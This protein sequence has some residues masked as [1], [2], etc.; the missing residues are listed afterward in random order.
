MWFAILTPGAHPS[1]RRPSSDA[2]V[3]SWTDGDRRRIDGPAWAV[4]GGLRVTRRLLREAGLPPAPPRCFV[5]RARVGVP[6]VAAERARPGVLRL[7]EGVAPPP[8]DPA[9]RA[10][11]LL[12]FVHLH[13]LA[14][15]EDP[16]L[17]EEALLVLLEQDFTLVAPL[18]I[19]PACL[20]ALR[21]LV[22]GEPRAG[23]G[24]C[25]T[26]LPGSADQ[27]ARVEARAA[28]RERERGA[29]RGHGRRAA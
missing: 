8:P 14:G 24:A 12:A 17:E 22:D 19:L 3:F 25:G 18:A 29:R 2:T 21:E 11:A 16:T 6:D 27:R 28:R 13:D 23:C 15:D 26:V 10:P 20:G 5:C 1:R 9:T 7:P 4:Q